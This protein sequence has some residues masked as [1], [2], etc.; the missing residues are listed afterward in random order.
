VLDQPIQTRAKQMAL[1]T[2]VARA[3]GA[4]EERVQGYWSQSAWRTRVVGW[5]LARRAAFTER[6][7]YTESLPRLV[8]RWLRGAR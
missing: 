7:V 3:N 4:I 1:T 8:W 2:T 6:Q 5:L